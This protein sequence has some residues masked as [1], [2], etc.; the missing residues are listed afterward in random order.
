MQGIDAVHDGGD[1][2]E[3]RGETVPFQGVQKVNEGIVKTDDVDEQ[4]GLS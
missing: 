2:A 1:W 3:N 4:D